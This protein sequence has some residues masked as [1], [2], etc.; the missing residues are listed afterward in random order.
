MSR[1]FLGG[2]LTTIL[3]VGFCGPGLAKDDYRGRGSGFYSGSELLRLC[4]SADPSEQHECSSYVCGVYDGWLALQVI[5]KLPGD[6][7][8]PYDICLPPKAGAV[9]CEQLRQAVVQ[10]LET[11]PELRRSEG[12]GV[13]GVA[14]HRAFPCC[15]DQLL[16]RPKP[17]P[18]GVPTKVSKPLSVTV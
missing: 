6:R 14:I 5:G 18:S 17:A 10:E 2:V 13:V 15:W 8:L 11:N 16:S 4:K 1:K 3:V 9:T 12:G 7:D